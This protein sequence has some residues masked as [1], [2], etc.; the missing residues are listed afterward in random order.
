MSDRAAADLFAILDALSGAGVEL[1][2]VGGVAAILHGAE[3]TTRDVDIDPER[4]RAG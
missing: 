4:T 2:V 3:L 1:V